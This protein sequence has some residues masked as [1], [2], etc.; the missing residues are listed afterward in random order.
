MKEKNENNKARKMLNEMKVWIKDKYKGNNKNYLIDIEKT[1]EIFK[2]NTE[3]LN[4][5]IKFVNSQIMQNQSKKQGSNLNY[6][7][8]IQ[9][10]LMNSI[11]NIN[12]FKSA[13]PP[14]KKRIDLSK[15]IN[16]GKFKN[17]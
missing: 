6:C 4:K 14:L 15:S 12:T 5:S 11:Q 13:E 9:N 2:G 16:F 7:N 10:N 8:S 17:I 3:L 1:Y